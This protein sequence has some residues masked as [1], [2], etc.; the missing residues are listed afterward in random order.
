VYDA[1]NV[2]MAM[3]IISKEKKDIRWLGLP[4]GL[5]KMRPS[6]HSRS[7]KMEE[8]SIESRILHKKK[9]LQ[10]LILQQVLY[11][12]VCHKRMKYVGALIENNIFQVAFKNLMERNKALELTR[13]PPAPSS[14]IHLPMLV[15]STNQNTTVNC[16]VSNDRQV[17]KHSKQHLDDLFFKQYYLTNL[18][19]IIQG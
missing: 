11:S 10:A 7:N 13:G 16:S 4:T 3:N 5:P 17:I 15:V 2:L 1:L 8:R 14:A 19:L 6:S 18:A 12:C 9:T